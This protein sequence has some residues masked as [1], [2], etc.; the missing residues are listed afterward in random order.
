[1]KK[2]LAFF[3]LIFN[4]LSAW[5][6]TTFKS[7]D[8]YYK[9][10][11]DSE[12]YAVEVTYQTQVPNNNYSGLTEVE[13][14]TTVKYN[15]TTYEVI[16]ISWYAF[17]ECADLR[18]V[19]IPNSIQTI[20][21]QA[22]EGCSSLNSIIIPNSV[23]RIYGDAFTGSGI[24]NDP[25]NWHNHAL[26]IG[27]WLIC[28]NP[29]SISGIYNIKPG[30][31]CIAHEAFIYC[32]ALKSVN[33]PNSVEIIGMLS[34]GI[35]DSLETLVIPSSVKHIEIGAAESCPSLNRIVVES[36]NTHYDSRDNCNAI[37]ETATNTLLSGCN[38]TVIPQSITHIA[39]Y[40]FDGCQFSS[41]SI[42]KGIKYIGDWAFANCSNLKVFTCE[43]AELPEL[44]TDIF[45]VIGDIPPLDYATPINE[46]TLFVPQEALEK[47]KT[48]DQ[49]YKFGTILPIGTYSPDLFPTLTG[50]QRTV[51]NEYCGETEE[52][53]S[54]NFTYK[55]TFDSIFFENDKPYILCNGYLLREEDNKIFLYSQSLNKDIVLYD[56]TLEVG[57]SLPT[58]IKDFDGT[59][60]SD[61]TLVVT[62]ISSVT[63]LDG[64]EYKKWTFNNGME[65]VEAIG[66]YGG[67]RN[68][69]F[70]GLIQ[71]V[72]VP[73]HIGTHLVCVSKNNQ[74]LYQM[75]DAEMERL[76]AECLC[77]GYQSSYKDQWC[78]TWNVLYHG[79]DPEGGDDPYMPYT[80]IYQL[81]E[82][83][84][85]NDLTY[86]RLTGRFSLS[87]MPLNKEYVAALRFAEHKK[88]FVHYDNTEYL[89]YD[90]GAQVGDTLE[91]FGGID[92]YKDFKT[93][94]HVITE[95]DSLDDGRLQ[96]YSN[97]IIQES[98]GYE[99]PFERLYPK[100]WIEGVGSKDGIVQNSATNR[101]GIGP[102]VLLCAYHNDDCIYTTDNPYYTPYG[103]VHNDSFFTATE[104][105]NAPTQ[106]VQKIMYNGQLLILRDGKIYNIMGVEMG[107]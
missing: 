53:N 27:D 70:F 25:S 61:N 47:Y 67:R 100:I 14:P 22:F 60:Y 97:A 72:V 32:E 13:I 30:T 81:E 15:K 12:P 20:H 9:I 46:A 16:G 94:T 19:L 39:D 38:T 73:C 48:A 82:D 26:Y 51:C 101:I 21:F 34:F 17:H 3:L 107:K 1:M 86:Q 18:S 58:Y 2:T 65:Y 83:T 4:T 71:E 7:G 45:S 29:D 44:G 96:I 87:T 106:S 40:A 28:T 103:C 69:N 95:I 75:D 77:D 59:M 102:C 55:Q 24:Y 35:C 91:I 33:I 52:D 37:I 78:D 104:E 63:L 49:W 50:L 54:A 5:A 85:I 84:T 64:K 57:D 10:V 66:M 99:T 98:E 74:L 6:A 79:W 8:L 76:G 68:G 62:D 89:L 88:V 105:V 92:H 31:R 93:L 11:S 90:F 43:A 42:P 41:F 23:T 80:F 56:F 36:G